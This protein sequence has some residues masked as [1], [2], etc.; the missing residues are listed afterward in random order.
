MRTLDKGG[1]KEREAGVTLITSGLLLWVGI[2]DLIGKRRKGRRIDTTTI[3]SKS[4]EKERGEGKVKA[5]LEV[6]GGVLIF[7]WGRD[8]EHEG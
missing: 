3:P 5:A 8:M 4:K 1:L 6:C 7:A 2:K